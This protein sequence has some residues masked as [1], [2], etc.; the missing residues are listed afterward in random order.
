MPGISVTPTMPHSCAELFD[1]YRLASWFSRPLAALSV[2]VAISCV[3][4]V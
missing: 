2:S 1:G 4:P 3:P